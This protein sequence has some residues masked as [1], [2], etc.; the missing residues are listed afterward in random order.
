M[1][2]LENVFTDGLTLI[3]AVF[4]LALWLQIIFGLFRHWGCWT[5]EEA[6]PLKLTGVKLKI[7][8]FKS[9]TVQKWWL[10]VCWTEWCWIPCLLLLHP[11]RTAIH[12]RCCKTQ[13]H[14]NLI[15]NMCPSCVQSST[16]AISQIKHASYWG[17]MTVSEG[18]STF[19]LLSV[20][21]VCRGDHSY[22]FHVRGCE[23]IVPGVH[24]TSLCWKWSSVL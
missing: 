18:N 13:K 12:K 3:S 20:S 5:Q 23:V 16:G 21:C 10:V 22:W 9:S 2:I 6:Q 17:I 1:W 15:W 14:A 7:N 19:L 11:G 4:P 8:Y 24:Q